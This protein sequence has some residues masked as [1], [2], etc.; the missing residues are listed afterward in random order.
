MFLESVCAQWVQQSSPCVFQHSTANSTA[1]SWTGMLASHA[2]HV[3]IGSLLSQLP[4]AEQQLLRLQVEGEHEWK[5]A[6]MSA[7]PVA[8]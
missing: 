2:T 7:V 6:E 5:R 8:H 4:A 1:E 3:K